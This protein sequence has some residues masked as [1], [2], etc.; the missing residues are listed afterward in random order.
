MVVPGNFTIKLPV[1]VG[2]GIFLLTLSLIFHQLLTRNQI[3]IFFLIPLLFAFSHI[4]LIQFK[5][6]NNFLVILII[7]FCTFVTTKYHLRFNQERKFHELNNVNFKLAVNAKKI[8]K[9]MLG[10]NWITPQFKKNPM[11]EIK[12][13][14]QIESLLKEDSR[15]KMLITNYPFFSILLDHKLY[16][17]SRVY[18][19]DG[20]THPLKGS[21]YAVKYKGSQKGI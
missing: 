21:E 4:N 1:S 19:S 13:I 6:K 2:R 17:P 15:N 12:I 3:F 5:K 7:L 9:K 16:S 10:L 11:E 14:N 8:H 18:T 20:T